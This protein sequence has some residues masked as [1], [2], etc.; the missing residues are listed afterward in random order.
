M[1]EENATIDQDL[2]D[3]DISQ[4][5]K[6]ELTTYR[7]LLPLVK[8]CLKLNHDIN[9]PL[10][11]ILG[12]AEL[13]LTDDQKL[14]TDQLKAVEKIMECG[15]RISSLTIEL[16][17]LKSQLVHDLDLKEAFPFLLKDLVRSE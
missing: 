5:L 12:Y 1:L 11:G 6:H 14:E 8:L 3:L 7:K 10:A 4:D 9:N 2:I 16:T 15:E 17:E 13:L